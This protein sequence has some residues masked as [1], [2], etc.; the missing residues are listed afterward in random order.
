M[1]AINPNRIIS[2]KQLIVSQKLTKYLSLSI[3]AYYGSH[4]IIEDAVLAESESGESAIKSVNQSVECFVDCIEQIELLQ[5]YI[6][7][8]KVEFTNS[9]EWIEY[10]SNLNTIVD[11]INIKMVAIVD[12]LNDENTKIAIGSFNFQDSMWGNNVNS[13]IRKTSVSCMMLFSSAMVLHA[14][15]VEETHSNLTVLDKAA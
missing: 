3:S 14:E 1:G 8:A 6:N 10:L 15:F 12:Q 7:I 13:E 11:S 5:R 9:A 2:K 4:A